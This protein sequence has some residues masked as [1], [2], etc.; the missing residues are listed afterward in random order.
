MAMPFVSV[1]V[2]EFTQ[3]DD[4]DEPKEKE[5]S[6]VVDLALQSLLLCANA[7]TWAD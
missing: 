1:A 6:L 3:T 5:L 7:T 2:A 4:G